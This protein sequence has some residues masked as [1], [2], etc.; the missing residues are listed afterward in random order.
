MNTSK[1]LCVV[2]TAIFAV[3]L[4]FGAFGVSPVLAN[5]DPNDP[6]WEDPTWVREFVD[7]KRNAVFGPIPLPS[8]DELPQAV[9]DALTHGGFAV[10]IEP[11]RVGC[12]VSPETDPNCN[13]GFVR[14]FTDWDELYNAVYGKVEANSGHIGPWTDGS[15]KISYMREVTADEMKAADWVNYAN[16]QVRVNFAENK[17]LPNEDPTNGAVAHFLNEPWRHTCVGKVS[18]L[19]C[20][21]G[22]SIVYQDWKEM[23]AYLAEGQWQRGSIMAMPKSASVGVNSPTLVPISVPTDTPVPTGNSAP[24]LTVVSTT[25]TPVPTTTYTLIASAKTPVPKD[26]DKN[27]RDGDFICSPD[28]TWIFA[29]L[30]GGETDVSD[31]TTNSTMENFPWWGWVFLAIMIGAILW[32]IF[33]PKGNQSVKKEKSEE[34]KPAVTKSTTKEE[35]AKTEPKK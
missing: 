30:S 17:P 4:I 16:G 23:L 6:R 14:S 32:L 25:N 5:T 29:P 33:R 7:G 9:K 27:T 15:V 20:N 22:E 34:A 31:P 19:N 10:L 12:P 3:A 13:V 2:F 11:W 26:C 35:P 1:I 24:T 21:V 8:S 18:D 28:G